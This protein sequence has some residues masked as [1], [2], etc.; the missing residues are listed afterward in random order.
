M[1]TSFTTHSA[2]QVIASADIDLIQT[3]V[4]ALEGAAPTSG[5]P[6]GG[7]LPAMQG[8]LGWSFDP[9]TS[10]SS[11]NPITGTVYATGV[12]LPAGTVTNLHL[13]VATGGA[14]THCAMG[15]YSSSGTLLSQTAD[16]TSTTSS[17]GLKTWALGVPQV[18]A[19]GYYYLA[20]A[21][22]GGSMPGVTS[23]AGITAAVVNAAT[24]AAPI[25]TR[26]SSSG[27]AYATVLPSPLGTLT[28]SA[29][30]VWAGAS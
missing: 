4:N 22:A 6:N 9:A 26:F 23:A 11:T 5:A 7:P 18:V 21:F 30:T 16:Q 19:A 15:L 13:Y 20:M 1:A 8:F 12:Y 3:A 28:G 17:T 2:G 29:K 10:N 27:T 25:Q 14:A 24:G